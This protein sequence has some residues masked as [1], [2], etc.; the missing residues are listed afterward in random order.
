MTEIIS[1]MA[2]W[3]LIGV[4]CYFVAERKNKNSTAW[5]IGGIILG[6]LALGYLL[7][8]IDD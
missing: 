7:L 8:D 6:F 5:L 2:I 4:V 1:I 3:T